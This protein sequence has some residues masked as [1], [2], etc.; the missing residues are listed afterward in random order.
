[1][2]ELQIVDD[3]LRRD[4]DLRRHL[5]TPV[6]VARDALAVAWQVQRRTA[7]PVGA[8]NRRHPAAVAPGPEVEGEDGLTPDVPWPAGGR[9]LGIT[10]DIEP[11]DILAAVPGGDADQ[12]PRPREAGE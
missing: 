11:Q 7:L 5:A 3:P 10:L 2:H 12:R 9:V 4:R 8:E 6:V 1:M